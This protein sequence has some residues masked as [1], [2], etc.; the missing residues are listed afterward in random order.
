MSHSHVVVTACVSFSDVV[1]GDCLSR[2]VYEYQ[3]V[4]AYLYKY[5]TETDHYL[6]EYK[7][8]SAPVYSYQ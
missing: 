5:E 4:F 7:Y 2:I 6:Y 8:D 1:G 3:H